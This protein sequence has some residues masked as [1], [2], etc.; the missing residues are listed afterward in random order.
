M[1][2]I[3][4]ILMLVAVLLTACGS[5]L[6][7]PPTP[8]PAATPTPRPSATLTVTPRPT[9]SA[10]ASFTPPAST[11]TETALPLPATPQTRDQ[12]DAMV[13]AGLIKCLGFPTGGSVQA[14]RF[15]E[16][17]YGAG[18]IPRGQL[19]LGSGIPSL[20]DPSQCLYLITFTKQGKSMIVY[21]DAVTGLYVKLPLT[22]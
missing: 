6:F 5:A 2:K 9:A 3:I 20:D 15:I 7:A 11:P 16:Q 13:R 18:V 12:F 1:P 14:T 17:A 19:T 21:K 10:T 8:T 4:A 22:D